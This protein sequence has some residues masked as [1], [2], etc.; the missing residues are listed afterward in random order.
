MHFSVFRIFEKN[1]ISHLH[2]SFN[3]TKFNPPH[4]CRGTFETTPFSKKLD[5]FLKNPIIIQ[6]KKSLKGGVK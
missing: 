3:I 4:L 2:I 1:A 5:F 6:N